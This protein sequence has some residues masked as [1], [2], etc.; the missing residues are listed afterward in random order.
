MITVKD[1]V[2]TVSTVTM[3]AVIKEGVLVSVKD[4]EGREYL[5][6]NASEAPALEIVYRNKETVAITKDKYAA[7]HCYALSDSCAEIRIDSLYGN[8]VLTIT[9]DPE[10]GDMC[11]E[12]EVTSARRGVLA[13]RYTIGGIAKELRMVAPFYQGIDMDLNDE[14]IVNRKWIWPHMWEAG[15]AIFHDG[16]RGFWVH[17]QDNQYRSKSLFIAG[18]NSAGFDAEAWGP[19][20]NSFSAGGI[21]WRVNVFR[22]GWKVPAARYRDWL[23]KAYAMEKEEKLR[24]D[25]IKD[26]RLAIS[27]CP[28]N[29]D[30]IDALAKKVDTKK[31]L[32]HLPWWRTKIYDQC[33]PDFTPS[34]E[35]KEFLKYANKL[36]FRCMP[37][38]NS[39]DMDPS[40]PEYRYVADFKYRDIE[41]ESFMGWSLMG[42]MPASNK[43]LVE[44]RNQNVMVK[45]H[46]GLAMWRSVLAENLDNALRQLEYDVSGLFLDVTLCTYNLANS[47]VDNTTTMEGM[48]RLISHVRNI[49]GGIPIGGEGLNEITM[50]KLSLGQVHL[51]DYNLNGE[52]L[53]RTGKCDLNQFLF[54]K[55]CRAIGYSG[56][57]GRTEEE[58]IR[59][60]VSEEHGTMPT[61]TI[62]NA[63]EIENP[64]PAAARL[65][66]MAGE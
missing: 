16:D 42:G 1:N 31:V 35:F 61:L 36:G 8:G 15:L 57:G 44:N 19:I 64:N 5:D 11:M 38:A 3:E 25:W 18:K 22:G 45:V 2:V 28:T 39:I 37:H 46:P 26:L 24:A 30:F 60:R 49:K 4:R 6:A 52:P 53:E 9:E 58:L 20:D 27:W 43:S 13:A 59:M 29:K 47:L 55:L 54:G 63:E 34:E 62:G 14:L 66:K 40:M 32:L 51:F 33:Y 23:W 7:M 56:L 17:C 48:Q 12:P 21:V 50:Q 41:N 65:L 10:T